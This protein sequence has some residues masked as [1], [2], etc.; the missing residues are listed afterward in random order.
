MRTIHLP[1]LA[2][3]KIRENWRLSRSYEFLTNPSPSLAIE[4]K[5]PGH[6]LG[7]KNTLSPAQKTSL[8][9]APDAAEQQDLV[10]EVVPVSLRF[11]M[12]LQFQQNRQ[13]WGDTI[14]N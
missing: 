9:L 14:S 10:G 2:F 12:I 5:P 4:W 1:A 11:E 7:G 3:N 8:P 13:K 6:P